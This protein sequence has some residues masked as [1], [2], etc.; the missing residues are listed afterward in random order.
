[1]SFELAKNA[2]IHVVEKKLVCF[3]IPSLHDQNARL[4][5]HSAPAA[6]LAEKGSASS[7]AAVELDIPDDDSDGCGLG[8]AAG[9]E[10]WKCDNAKRRQ[11]YFQNIIWEKKRRVPGT[12]AEAFDLVTELEKHD[13][14]ADTR[15]SNGFLEPLQKNSIW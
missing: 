12:V 7:G 2:W 9:L 15:P 10:S 6:F 1:M 4:K 11:R 14:P 5:L 8:D 3:C 13:C